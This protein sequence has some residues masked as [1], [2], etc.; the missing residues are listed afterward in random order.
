MRVLIVCETSG[1]GRKAWRSLG[2]DCWSCDILPSED[3]SPFH[4]VGDALDVMASRSWDAFGMH[5]PCQYLNSAGIHWNNR[6]RGWEQTDKALQFVADMVA[7]AGPAPYYL[8]NSIGILSTRWRKP[9][10]IVQPYHFGDDAS[11]ATCLWLQHWQPLKMGH[12]LPGRMV[13]W[14]RGSGK[15]VERWS[16]QTDSGQNKLPPSADRWKLRSRSYPG[17]MNAI[18]GQFSQQLSEATT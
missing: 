8:E 2:V 3:G 13:E 11:K 6:G 10:Q 17:I 14:P 12:R 15:I 9:D 7:L 16:N 1:I 4:I 18:A 5:P